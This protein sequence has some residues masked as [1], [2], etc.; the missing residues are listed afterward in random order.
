MP[1]NNTQRAIDEA[2]QAKQKLTALDAEKTQLTTRLAELAKEHSYRESLLS[3]VL[4]HPSLPADFDLDAYV[5]AL[6]AKQEEEKPKRRGRKTNAEKAA[7]AATKAAAE[8]DDEP[9]AG[10]PPNEAPGV[11]TDPVAV[12]S[13]DPF[14]QL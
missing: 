11:V 8:G 2:V 14:D 3:T 6:P 9:A 7:E 12:E 5:A 13:D 4:L 1:V 10:N